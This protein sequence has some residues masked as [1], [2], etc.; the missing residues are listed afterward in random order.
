M[1]RHCIDEPDRPRVYHRPAS[2][3]RQ[4]HAHP[5]KVFVCL[6][7]S[8]V[9][10]RA[11]LGLSGQRAG[12][13]CCLRSPPPFSPTAAPPAAVAPPLP[14]PAPGARP[15]GAPAALL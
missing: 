4:P 11:E 8:D 12:G 1:H 9:L 6:S 2:G 10:D 15:A 13:P 5:V 7:R 3:G 14:A